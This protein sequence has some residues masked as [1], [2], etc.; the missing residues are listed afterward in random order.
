[1]A[2]ELKLER[3]KEVTCLDTR[4]FFGFKNIFFNFGDMAEMQTT[5]C[6][7]FQFGK[8]L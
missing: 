8:P 3:K 2:S 6:I 7:I 4:I 1:M 5:V